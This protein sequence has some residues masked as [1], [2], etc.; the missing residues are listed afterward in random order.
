MHIIDKIT[1]VVLSKNEE[2]HIA[3]CL[4][5]LAWCGRV[6]VL[7]SGSSDRT[8]E[9]AREMGVEVHFRAFD[10]FAS[11]RNAAIAL[12]QTEW[13]L[14]IDADERVPQ[15]LADEIRTVIQHPQ[16]DGWMIPT[17]NYYFGKILKYGGFYPDYHLRLARKAK[18]FFEENQK[19][20]EVPTLAGEFGYLNE[21]LIHYCYDNH[22][23]L[24]RAK[25]KYARLL[26]EIH[27]EKG[28]KPTYHLLAAPILTFFEQLICKKG[29][30]DGWLGFY[31]SLMWGYYAFEEYRLARVLWQDQKKRAND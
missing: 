14:F 24:K 31:I 26:A 7:D 29:F 11:Q 30:K 4:G 21:P 18:F 1:S 22:A 13:L 10:N 3:E 12:V 23:E 5:S 6:L 8:V 9:I 2:Q 28:L 16:F 19:V 20:H 15:A 27:F 25:D 17:R